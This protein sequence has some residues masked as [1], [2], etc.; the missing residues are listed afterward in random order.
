[1]M[2]AGVCAITGLGAVRDEFDPAVHLG[3]K[4]WR[5]LPR[6]T[7]AGLVAA[8]LALEGAASTDVVAERVGVAVGTNFAIS[9]ISDEIDRALLRGGLAEISPMG[10]PNFSINL[11]ASQVSMNHRLRAFNITLLSLLT[12]GPEAI[13]LGARALRAGRADAVLVGA[14][15]GRAEAG[16]EAVCGPPALDSGAAGLLHLE[17]LD[18]ALE[19]G[20]Q[21]LATLHGGLNRLLPVEPGRRATSATTALRQ[22]TG[23]APGATQLF[24]PAGGDDAVETAARQFHGDREGFAV[25]RGAAQASATSLLWL[26]DALA[27]VP[28]AGLVLAV[29]GPQGHFILLR[30]ASEGQNAGST[31]PASAEQ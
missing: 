18:R 19:R 11:P 6:A 3:R 23:G 27:R 24:L 28:A 1:M 25:V 9:E 20:V 12:A 17:R 26:A 8:K 14:I 16:A 13:L 21:V 22:L 30:F 2:G 31:D 10:C 15:E 4:G 7:Q 29:L 5:F